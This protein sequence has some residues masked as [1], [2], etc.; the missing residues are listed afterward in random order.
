MVEAASARKGTPEIV[1]TFSI[2]ARGLTVEST[3]NVFVAAVSVRRGTPAT[4]AGRVLR[5]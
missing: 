3:D 4:D 5:G 1:V 2:Y